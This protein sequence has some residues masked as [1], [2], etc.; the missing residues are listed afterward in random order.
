MKSTLY[1]RLLAIALAAGSATA[2]FA[3]ERPRDTG[4]GCHHAAN[5]Y[6]R[7]PD[8]GSKPMLQGVLPGESLFCI[9]VSRARAQ[10]H[11]DTKSPE[12][13]HM[14]LAMAS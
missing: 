13:R 2:A 6:C 11:S 10:I 4:V 1:K 14:P 8:E 7:L 9:N 5:A 12:V 3:G